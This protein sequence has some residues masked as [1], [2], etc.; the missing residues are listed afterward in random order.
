MGYQFGLIGLGVMGRNFALNMAEN[1][2]SVA[3]F[4]LDNEKCEAFKKEGNAF[5]VNAWDQLSEFVEN[6]ETPRK[7]MLLVPAGPPVD[8]VIQDLLPVIDEGDLIIDGGNSFFE[9]TNRRFEQL[10]ARKIHFMGMGVSGGSEGARKGPSLMPGGSLHSYEM[11]K[12]MLEAAAAKVEGK[13]CV[14]FVGNT[15][16]GN[17]VKM[18]H[19]GIEYAMMQLISEVYAAMKSIGLD[20]VRMSDLF[21][22]W[23]EGRLQSFLIEIT[24]DILTEKDPD[25]GKYL[26]E[27]IL[28]KG[29][30]KGTGKWTSQNAFDLGIPIPSIDAAVTARGISS[31]KMLRE[32]GEYLFPKE[33]HIT[34]P[35]NFISDLEKALYTGFILC[36]AQGFHLIHAA[37]DEYDYGIDMKEVARIWRGGCII[38]AAM[39]DDIYTTFEHNPENSILFFTDPLR[40]ALKINISGLQALVRFT[41]DHEI[42]APVASASYQYFSSLTTHL[43]P[44]NMVQAQRDYFGSHTYERIDKKGVYHTEWSKK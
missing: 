37:N 6:L 38:R 19:N 3:G 21:G 4:D 23:N 43:L 36:Y 35:E 26:V 1:G 9:D 24:R 12:P 8:H 30:Q 32:T 16:A 18:V 44:M 14:T 25:T 34:Q 40:S 2:F 29:K 7:I 42:A 13:P 41:V 39:L 33:A 10:A 15:S 11:V 5:S 28:D 22:Q 17:Y 20:H 31:F 27:L